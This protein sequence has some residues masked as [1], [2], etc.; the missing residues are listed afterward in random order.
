MRAIAD[1]APAPD[2]V[3]VSVS[4]GDT[5]EGLA[6]ATRAGV[7]GILELLQAWLAQ[8]GLVDSRLVLFTIGA[9]AVEEGEV[10]DLAAASV[11]GLLRSAQSEHPDRFLIVDV[12]PSSPVSE[13]PGETERNAG[14][15]ALDWAELLAA[16]EPQLAV[17]EGRVYVP[18]LRADHGDGAGG[19]PTGGRRHGA[20]H[21]WH[22]N[23]GGSR[24]PP[25]GERAW[26]STPAAGEPSRRG[27]RGR[28]C[29]L[30]QLAEL[31]CEA[32]IVA[33]DVCDRDQVRELIESVAPEY[34]L[35]A[36][37]HTAGA[38]RDGTIESLT[39][40]QVDEAMRP[41]V[42]AAL[43]LHERAEDLGLAEFVLFSSASGVLGGAGQGSA[44]RRMRFWMRWRRCD[45]RRGRPACRSLGA[46]G[47]RRVA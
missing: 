20:D 44:Q 14:V 43:H 31:G 29:F 46:F 1:G 28:E 19:S 41:K 9:V 45:G 32:S 30:G 21:G 12:E 22:R 4:V 38:V 26:G 8:P 3:C 37:I 15:Q 6:R 42:D 10:P 35:T 36:V 23:S 17:R 7:K 25:P 40:E 24:G 18:R 13:D 39:A 11:W 34:P 16:G 27:G 47:R 2:A 33:C 5:G